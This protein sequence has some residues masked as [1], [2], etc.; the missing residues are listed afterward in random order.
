MGWVCGC[1]GLWFEAPFLSFCVL[2]WRGPLT[3]VWCERRGKASV[4]AFLLGEIFPRPHA[5]CSW[6]WSSMQCEP[7]GHC[8]RTTVVELSANVARQ[9]FQVALG[10]IRTRACPCRVANR[11]SRLSLCAAK[12]RARAGESR[13]SKPTRVMW[14]VGNSANESVWCAVR[15]M[16]DQARERSC[17]VSLSATREGMMVGLTTGVMGKRLKRAV[18]KFV[19][20][21]LVAPS[22]STCYFDPWRVRCEP[23][24]MCTLNSEE[25]DQPDFAHGHTCRLTSSQSSAPASL[26]PA[27]SWDS[28]LLRCEQEGKCHPEVW[29]WAGREMKRRLWRARRL[30]SI[31]GAALYTSALAMVNT[32]RIKGHVAYKRL[33]TFA[34]ALAEDTQIARRRFWRSMRK[35]YAEAK[36]AVGSACEVG[37]EIQDE[38]SHLAAW[39]C[40]AIAWHRGVLAPMLE[41]SMTKGA[42]I[43]AQL[44][45]QVHKLSGQLKRKAQEFVCS[46]KMW[47]STTESMLIKMVAQV[48]HA[49]SDLHR[50]LSEMDRSQIEAGAR[51]LKVATIAASHK[52][53]SASR[54]ALKRVKD[55]SQRKALELSVAWREV[56]SRTLEKSK[57]WASSLVSTCRK[58]IMCLCAVSL[59]LYPSELRP[60]VDRSC[61]P[62]EWV[63]THANGGRD[64]LVNG[65][66][67]MQSVL[68]PKP[69][70]VSGLCS[71]GMSVLERGCT[72]SVHAREA[73]KNAV[74]SLRAQYK[75]LRE[76]G[77]RVLEEV[78]VELDS[79]TD[80]QK[81]DVCAP[82][83]IEKQVVVWRWKYYSPWSA[84]TTADI[85][86][87]EILRQL[88]I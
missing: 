22:N 41:R 11:G 4:T 70:G 82:I 36:I 72:F 60:S 73:I 76:M 9:T 74:Q 56:A 26:A 28:N 66:R 80:R 7:C 79:A 62:C 33:R 52:V 34:V 5:A 13:R 61:G 81:V 30:S 12:L 59:P 21:E 64:A 84:K 19:E 20:R 68:E 57:Y 40:S 87:G 25:R 24:T 85:I 35:L 67:R 83:P 88:M 32:L 46:V 47:R 86:H 48:K 23:S 14:Q 29:R 43:A 2:A 3:H 27:C 71:S 45:S 15:A 49:V 69:F 10:G 51:H 65:L 75:H 39:R 8:R 16:D 37:D 77:V 53:V 18:R 17:S 44:R 63:R 78:E 31:F 58:G 38:Q 54:V 55:A 1:V 50:T 42:A 6:D